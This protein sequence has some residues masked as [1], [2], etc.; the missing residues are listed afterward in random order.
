MAAVLSIPDTSKHQ[1]TCT[2][3][4]STSN[5]RFSKRS[6]CDVRCA[7]SRIARPGTRAKGRRVEGSKGKRGPG[8]GPG[9]GVCGVRR[10]QQWPWAVA[11]GERVEELF[12]VLCLWIGFCCLTAI[13]TGTVVGDVPISA[14]IKK[15]AR[16]RTGFRIKIRSEL[17]L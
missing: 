6:L 10:S 3:N 11:S 9:A 12:W 7:S 17:R 16:K 14:V 4:F 15:E 1:G 13:G 8:Q 5:I 2:D